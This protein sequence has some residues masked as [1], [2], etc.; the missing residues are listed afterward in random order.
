MEN[1]YRVRAE[2]V[3]EWKKRLT[4]EKY[5]QLVQK[6]IDIEDVVAFAREWDMALQ[7]VL[8]QLEVKS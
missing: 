8:N 5:E 4:P 3:E 2:H 1:N 6:G 7:R